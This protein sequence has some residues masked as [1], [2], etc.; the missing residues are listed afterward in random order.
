VKGSQNRGTWK[1]RSFSLALLG[2][3]L[4]DPTHD[5]SCESGRWLDGHKP[6]TEMFHQGLEYLDGAWI[7]SKFRLP[8][9]LSVVL[10]GRDW[11]HHKCGT[12]KPNDATTQCGVPASSSPALSLNNTRCVSPRASSW[13]VLRN[14][15]IKQKP[16]W[17]RIQRGREL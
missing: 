5:F 12:V 3:N 4:F 8:H 10:L 6:E 1:Y 14:P 11:N 17:R 16:R 9:L 7:R 15:G 2:L 13:T